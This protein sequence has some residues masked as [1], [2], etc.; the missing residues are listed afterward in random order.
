MIEATITPSEATIYQQ[1]YRIV[2]DLG[3]ICNKQRITM[4]ELSS[5]RRESLWRLAISTSA[6]NR[7]A[8]TR[9]LKT[10]VY[11][12]LIAEAMGI[13]KDQCDVL[14]EAALL[15]DIGMLGVI[16]SLAPL[17]RVLSPREKEL[18]HTH[19]KIG[20]ELLGGGSIRELKLA[21]EIALTH[22]EQFDGNGYPSQLSKNQIPLSGRIVA[23]AEYLVEMTSEQGY[24]KSFLEDTVHEF[25]KM[26]NGTRF[27]P[28]VIETLPGLHD[29]FVYAKREIDQ[30][31]ITHL[32]PAPSA[33]LW[34][35]LQMAHAANLTLNAAAIFQS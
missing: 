4:T 25:I 27:D 34:K 9:V 8:P 1:L 15:R 33:E 5:V 30:M 31:P 11:A 35:N 23:V 29:I 17:A 21:A 22:H 24:R 13:P 3:D 6:W 14:Q 20:Y 7:W 16:E 10:G 28:E 32:T 2:D 26:E 19:P 18:L 12:A